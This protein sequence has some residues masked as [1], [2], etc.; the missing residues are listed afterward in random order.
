MGVGTGTKTKRKEKEK[1]MT[2]ENDLEAAKGFVREGFCCDCKGTRYG[3]PCSMEDYCDG[4]KD[5]VRN[6][7][8]EIKEE[9]EEEMNKRKTYKW[10]CISEKCH[11]FKLYGSSCKLECPIDMEAHGCPFVT[12]DRPNWVSQN[13]RVGPPVR[14]LKGKFKD[15]KGTIS[16]IGAVHENGFYCFV[17]RPDGVE[18]RFIYPKDLEILK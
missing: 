10:I 13:P 14:I 18:E 17:I 15:Q 16:E 4:F 11:F 7:L 6:L 1:E 12:T 3:S 2:N 5:E 8:K 9:K